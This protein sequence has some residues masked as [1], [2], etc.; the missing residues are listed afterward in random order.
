VLRLNL[1]LLA[2]GC[3]CCAQDCPGHGSSLDPAAYMEALLS[4]L[5]QQQERDY[6]LLQGSVGGLK[7]LS[8]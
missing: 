3:Y 2:D 1:L 7:A 6:Q 5:L 4:F 8:K